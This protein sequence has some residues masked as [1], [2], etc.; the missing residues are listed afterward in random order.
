MVLSGLVMLGMARFIVLVYSCSRKREHH[1]QGNKMARRKRR[2]DVKKK[3][4]LWKN[5]QSICIMI[6]VSSST[7]M[8]Y[9]NDFLSTLAA[10]CGLALAFMAMSMEG[11]A[12]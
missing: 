8:M 3:I 11:L 1:I 6:L 5:V 9:R 10:M 2:M 12:K 4:A 7:I